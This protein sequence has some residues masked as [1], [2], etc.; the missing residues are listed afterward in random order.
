MKTV[1]AVH[2]LSC[3]AK[4]SLTVVVP[5]LSAM[6]IEVSPLPTALLSTQTD[7]F[8]NYFYKNLHTEQKMIVDHW[9]E[10]DLSFDAVYSGFLGNSESIDMMIKIIEWQRSHDDLIVVDPVMGDNGTLYGPITDDFVSRM[11]QLVSFSD[12]LT[13]NLTEAALLLDEKY[14]ENLDSDTCASWAKRLSM[15]GPSKVVITSVMEK[16]NSVVVSYEKDHDRTAI[17]SQT[18]FPVSYPGC[19][20]LFTSILCGRLI[21]PA[22]FTSAVA[23]SAK[24]VKLAIKRSYEDHVAQSHGVSPE[25]IVREL[26]SLSH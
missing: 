9:K 21:I 23:D 15:M 11:K 3:Y 14:D 7:G 17:F 22:D 24:L 6:G 2:D 13:P 25:R 18:H 12:V 20:D 10:L 19:G 16:E 4:S 26:V 1:L 8:D 5:A